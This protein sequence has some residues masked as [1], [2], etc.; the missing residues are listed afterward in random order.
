[1]PR[2]KK[3]PRCEVISVRTNRERLALLKRYQHALADQLG[4]PISVA[5]AA[6][7]VL[8]GRAIGMDRTASRHEMLQTPTASL[9]RIRKRWA[10]QH[11]LAAAEWDVLAEYVQIA[12]DIERPEPCR[13]QPT[14]PSRDSYLALLDVFEAVYQHRND[15]ASQHAWQYVNNLDGAATAWRVSDDDADQGHQAVLNQI[16]HHRDL[17]RLA[18]PRE[19]TGNI[20]WCVRTA[21]REEGVDSVTLDHLLAPYWSMLWALAARG[22]WFRYHQPV[23]AMKA[24]EADA[25][26]R[27]S[28]PSA[29]TR[30]DL[31]VSFAPSESTDFTTE[32]EFRAPRQWG[33]RICRYPEWMEFRAMLEDVSDQSW[34]GTYFSTVVARVQKSTTRTLWLKQGTLRVELSEAQWHAL[35]DLFRQAWQNPHLQLS[36]RELQQEYGAQG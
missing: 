26:H 10:S 17:L 35:R 9:D 4:R 13:I 19:R 34:N 18:D 28:L 14:I 5:E 1:M 8:E 33:W 32:I 36:L 15:H 11:S 23:R 27:I 25:P 21:I 6:F 20:G 31:T 30:G 29:I 16:A 3:E 2:V 22:H 12:A 7:L 24:T